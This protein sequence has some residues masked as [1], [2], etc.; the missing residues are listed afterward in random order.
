MQQ[1]F[2]QNPCSNPP[3]AFF[4]PLFSSSAGLALSFKNWQTLGIK[5]A[6]FELETLLKRPGPH[7]KL[8]LKAYTGW[9]GEAIINGARLGFNKKGRALIRGQGGEALFLQPEEL[10]HF[11]K[12]QAVDGILLPQTLKDKQPQLLTALSAARLFLSMDEFFALDSIPSVIE[13]FYLSAKELLS[14][15]L[16]SFLPA[17]L[18]YPC[19]LYDVD[20]LSVVKNLPFK[21]IYVESNQPASDACQ[22]LVYENEGKFDIQAPSMVQDYRPLDSACACPACQESFTRAYFHHLFLQVPLLCQRFLIQ[23]N[24][25]KTLKSW[26]TQR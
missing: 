17:C 21:T 7:S 2:I 1:T 24:L 8:S 19:Y 22:G 11:L 12:Q 16:E 15:K 10:S 5:S 4:L 9:Q 25:L 26:V 23:H 14:G 20:D 6:A 13:G 18:N 3:K